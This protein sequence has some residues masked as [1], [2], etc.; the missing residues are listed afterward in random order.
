MDQS[1]TTDAELTLRQAATFQSI[2]TWI[3][4]ST[5]PDALRNGLFSS[6]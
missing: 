4:T 1:E 2:D 6:F 3:N 5:T